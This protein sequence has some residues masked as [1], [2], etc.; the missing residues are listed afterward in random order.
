[1]AVLLDVNILVTLLWT[2][3]ESHQRVQAW[4]NKN[5]S[6]GWATCPFTQAGF[7]RMVSNPSFSPSAVTVDEA[8]QVLKQSVAHPKHEFWEADI[9]Y[10]EATKQFVDRIVG[11]RQVTDAYLLGLAMRNNGKL[12]TMDRGI[13]HLV[14][15]DLLK[16]S[17]VLLV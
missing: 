6:K 14:A 12:A 15:D 11:H 13:P 8:M 1:M 7:V 4:F 3:Q 9:E 17:L 2:A 5:A 10:P 16:Q